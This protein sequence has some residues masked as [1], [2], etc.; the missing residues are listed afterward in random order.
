MHN[1]FL[2]PYSDEVLDQVARKKSFSF[3]NGFLGYHQVRIVEKDKK[4]TTFITEWGTFS[5]NIILFVLNNAPT[6]FSWIII[7]S[8]R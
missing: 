4:K 7:A 2:T 1:P 8:F 5:Y 6:L 3:T